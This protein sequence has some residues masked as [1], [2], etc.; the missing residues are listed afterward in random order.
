VGPGAHLVAGRALPAAAVWAQQRGGERAS[1]HG[2][3]AARRPGKQPGMGHPGIRLTAQDG[4]RRAG[5][6]AQ[7]RDDG[8]L[9]DQVAEN[10]GAGWA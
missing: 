8:L 10:P 2:P 9:A 4:A 3:A 5:G 6:P 7:F 1:R